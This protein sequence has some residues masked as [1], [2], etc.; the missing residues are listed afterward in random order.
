MLEEGLNKVSE[1]RTRILNSHP[2]TYSLFKSTKI[3]IN[4]FHWFISMEELNREELK[5]LVLD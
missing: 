2:E 1:S 4:L 3:K 5:T